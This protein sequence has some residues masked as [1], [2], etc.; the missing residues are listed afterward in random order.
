[1]RLITFAAL[2]DF[3]ATTGPRL[4]DD[5]GLATTALTFATALTIA[6][7]VLTFIAASGVAPVMPYANAPRTN[8]DTRLRREVSWKRDGKQ[9]SG[10]TSKSEY[11]EQH[12]FLPSALDATA[13]GPP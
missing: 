9:H 4:A 1:V 3:L 10:G 8:F 12:D 5:Y 11:T 2:D 6:T 13:P 7:A